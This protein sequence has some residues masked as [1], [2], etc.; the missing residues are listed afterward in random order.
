MTILISKGVLFTAVVCI[1]VLRAVLV[2]HELLLR[3]VLKYFWYALNF[4]EKRSLNFFAGGLH[5][6]LNHRW[7]GGENTFEVQMRKN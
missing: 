6:L 3:A 4:L 1:P 5:Q 2:S 7:G